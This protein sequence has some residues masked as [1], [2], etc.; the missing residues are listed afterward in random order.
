MSVFGARSTRNLESA[1]VKL[2]VLF[3]EVV[4]GWDCSVLCGERCKAVQ[5]TLFRSGRS[6][7]KYPESK[8][9]SS[10]S[11]AVDVAPYPVD[12][13]DVGRFYM[14]AGYVMRVAEEL[15]ISV[16]YGGDWDGDKRTADQTFNDLPHWELIE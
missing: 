13:D 5:D 1:D 7:V 3:A 16:R 2:Q 4:K 14:F 6:K 11:K 9:N 12:W 8:H 15:G 10:P